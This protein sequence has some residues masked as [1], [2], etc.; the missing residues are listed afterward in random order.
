MSK[1]NLRHSV[2]VFCF[3][4]A[5]TNSQAG[6]ELDFWH[7]YTHQPTGVTHFSFHIANYKRGFFFGSCGL[8][9]KSLQ[10]QYDVDLAG[11]GPRYTS[12]RIAVRREGTEVAIISGTIC[13]DAQQRHATIDLQTG[14]GETNSPAAPSSFIGNGTHR[15]RKLK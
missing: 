5:L 9:T 6:T 11:A 8:G 12:D 4:S 14:R 7:S 15:I 1:R 3:L 10:W 13:V 2:L